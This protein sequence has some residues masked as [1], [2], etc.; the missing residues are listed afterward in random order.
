[1]SSSLSSA[2]SAASSA[3]SSASASA[4]AK[5]YSG[6]GSGS[7]MSTT[8]TI[9]T[10]ITAILTILAVAAAGIYF[11]G[12]ADDV[13][14]WFAKKYYKGKAIAEVKVFENAGSEKLQSMAK[15]SLKKNPV[16]GEGELD[17]VSGG[18]GKEAVS[19]GLGG[20]SGKLGGLG[21]L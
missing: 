9:F 11:A 17:Q 10:S 20:V 1:M 3:L 5:A 15:D 8:G 21:N 16:M 19:D 7:G 14:E 6:S 18:L 2:K 4:T 13:A 12:Y